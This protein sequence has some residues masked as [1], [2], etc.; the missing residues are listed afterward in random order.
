MNKVPYT[1]PALT[2][3]AMI[4]VFS[5]SL[6]PF[7]YTDV[8]NFSNARSHGETLSKIQTEYQ[9]S[10]AQFIKAFRNKYNDRF[11]PSWTAFEVISFGTISRLY[12]TINPGKSKREVARYFGMR[13]KAFTSWLHGLVYVRNVCAHH[14][15]L[16]NRV[17]RIQPMKPASPKNQW[18]NNTEIPNN[19]TY[20]LLSMI[21]YLLDSIE[22]PHLIQ[23]E[24]K[25]LLNEYPQVHSAAM[26]FPDDWKNESLWK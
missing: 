23:D 19:R 11:P 3:A 9:R 20:F 7:W 17:L 8:G 14:S 4:Y 6:G 15:R 21:I 25:I 18:L 26:G 2:Y 12:A 16:W 1:K 13:D 10:D 5:H 22:E 24:I